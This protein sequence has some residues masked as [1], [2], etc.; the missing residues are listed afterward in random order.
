MESAITN[1]VQDLKN[2]LNVHT[3]IENI[4]ELLKSE[5]II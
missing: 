4:N 5:K 2:K 1:K 3:F